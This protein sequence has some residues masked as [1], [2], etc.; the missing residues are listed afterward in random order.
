MSKHLFRLLVALMSISLIG[1]ICIQGFWVES[2][3]QFSKNKFKENAQQVLDHCID[4]ELI[5]NVITQDNVYR[6]QKRLKKCFRQHNIIAKLYFKLTDDHTGQVIFKTRKYLPENGLYYN[7]RLT[8]NGSKY[9]FEII[10]VR[11]QL[12]LLGDVRIMAMLS[13]VFISIIIVAYSNALM[14]LLKQRHLATMKTDFV[15]NMT[16]ELKTP[17]ATISLALDTIQS[18]MLKDH[19][20]KQQSY[21]AIIRDENTRMKQQVEQ[22][23]M[24]SKLEDDALL[25]EKT[26]VD[27]HQIII[28]AIAH[29]RLLLDSKSGSITT[30][31]KASKTLVMGNEAHLKNVMINLFENAIKYCKVHPVIDVYTEDFKGEL[32]LKIQDQGIG[33]SKPAQEKAFDKF[34]RESTGNVHNVKGYGLG[35]TYV[36]NIIEYH[37]ADISLESQKDKGTCFRIKI[38]TI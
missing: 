20:D 28:S 8:L 17:L 22:L 30:H 7:T 5:E 1:I 37:D 26:Q 31:L 15:N 13:L 10:F 3:L 35:L 24:L 36:K 4:K 23:L 21:L 16:H 38:K 32:V 18:P 25:I 19:P 11:N 9:I 29:V 14:Q 34:F 2:T 33:M 12:F 27:L 6:L